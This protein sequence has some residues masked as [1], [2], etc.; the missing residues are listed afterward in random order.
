MDA[1]LSQDLIL[2]SLPE[3]F[4]Q[5]VVNYHIN[6]LDIF[7]LELLNMLKIAKNHIKGERGPLL[8]VDKNKYGRKGSKKG[9][10]LNPKRSTFK[11]KKAKHV[12]ADMTCY[13]YGKTGHWKRNCKSFLAKM[14]ENASVAHKGVTENQRAEEK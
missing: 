5:F 12:P 3:S 10:K 11:K 14:K 6:K 8:M 9:K 13:H 7:L 1:E 4:S 2:Q